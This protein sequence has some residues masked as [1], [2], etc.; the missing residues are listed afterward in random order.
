MALAIGG[1]GGIV[2]GDRSLENFL[3]KTDEKFIIILSIVKC[4]VLY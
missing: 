3:Y 2:W 1:G 4:L